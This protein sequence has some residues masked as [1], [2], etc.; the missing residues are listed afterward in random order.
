MTDE[1][2]GQT[3]R[4]TGYVLLGSA[5]L[6]WLTAMMMSPHGDASATGVV[7]VKASVAVFARNASLG[8]LLLVM[9]AALALFWRRKPRRNAADLIPIVL[10][11]LLAASSF[12]QLVWIETEVLDVDTQPAIADDRT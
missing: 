3:R 7:Y 4:I 11:A 9:L 10:M 5:A 6:V 2:I 12:Y 1:E 8:I